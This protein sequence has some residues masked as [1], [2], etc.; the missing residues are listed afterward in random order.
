M[1]ESVIPERMEFPCGGCGAPT[2][3]V[4]DALEYWQQFNQ[5]LRRTGQGDGLRVSEAVMC[6][7]CYRVHRV[8]IWRDIPDR[9]DEFHDVARDLRAKRHVAQARIQSVLEGPFG[10]GLHLVL[11]W[12]RLNSDRSEGHDLD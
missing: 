2:V 3:V 4:R 1:R 7:A 12:M 11:A 9:L 10:N 5:H 6:A 8:K